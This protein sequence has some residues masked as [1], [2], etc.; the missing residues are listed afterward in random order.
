M[1]KWDELIVEHSNVVKMAARKYLVGAY[2][3][4]IDDAVQEVLLK[5]IIKRENYSSTVVK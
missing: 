5:A 3:D 2:A 4:W 1:E